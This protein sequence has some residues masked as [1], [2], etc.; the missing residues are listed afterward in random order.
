LEKT[1]EVGM[2]R[3]LG[4]THRDVQR[5]FLTEAL[6][7]GLLGGI[8]GVILALLTGLVVNVAVS[9]LASATGNESATL[10]YAPVLLVIAMFVIAAISSFLTG[11]YPARRAAKTRILDALRYE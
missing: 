9:V 10:F 3:A 4:A 7:I 1:R 5:L 2:M 8:T 6:I 11:L